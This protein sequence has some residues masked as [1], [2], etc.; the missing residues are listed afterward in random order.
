MKKM[1]FL[2]T[3]LFV[4]YSTVSIQAYRFNDWTLTNPQ[5]VKFLISTTVG[6]YSTMVTTCTKKWEA[7]PEIKVRA[8]EGEHNIYFY[9]RYDMDSGAYAIARHYSNDSHTVTLYRRFHQELSNVEQQETVVHEVGHCLGLAH[10]E[11][12]NNTIS[13]MR[14]KGFNNKPY[15]L[16]DDKQGIAAKY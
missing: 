3:F 13:V 4:L 8:V 1:V 15:P 10:C 7:C 12:E 11:E 9:A 2:F 6:S 14:E 16:S 5:D